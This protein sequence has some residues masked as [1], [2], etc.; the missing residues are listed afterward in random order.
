MSNLEDKLKEQASICWV[1]DNKVLG[2]SLNM[3]KDDKG[4]DVVSQCNVGNT[5][6]NSNANGIIWV[7]N[8]GTS[9][10][11]P[12]ANIPQTG[13]SGNN[14]WVIPSTNP[15]T[16][17]IFPPFTFPTT[18]PITSPTILPNYPPSYLPAVEEKD[19]RGNRIV[20]SPSPSLELILVEI[21]KVLRDG[22]DILQIRDIFE[23]HK[24]KLVDHDG[25]TIFDP[26]KIEDLENK[27]F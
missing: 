23:R 4:N 2:A 20:K 11:S 18:P 6:D 19:E 14:P 17:P 15:N 1:S 21:A 8:D 10:N 12:W 24:L 3:Y 25:E 27:G 26:R 13:T 22:G 16:A 5:G 7:V 9:I